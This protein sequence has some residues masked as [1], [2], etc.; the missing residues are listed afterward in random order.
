MEKYLVR[1]GMSLQQL[2]TLSVIHVTGTKGKG[3]TCAFVEAILRNHGFRTGFYSSPHLVAVRE[4]FR[5]NAKPISEMKFINYFW[6]VYNML[7]QLKDNPNDMPPYFKFLTILMFHIFIKENVDV[8]IIEVGIGGELDCT[9][10]VRNSVCTGIAR[11]GL[12]HTSVLGNTLESIAFQKSGIFKPGA[13][14]FTIPQPRNA[15]SVLH[16]R[17]VEKGC[18]LSIVPNLQS[19]PWK[20]SQPVLGIP[21][22]VQN[23]N[24]SLAIQLASSWMM[25]HKRRGNNCSNTSKCMTNDNDAD[26]FNAT[27]NNNYYVLANN[28]NNSPNTSLCFAKVATALETCKW[29][30]RTQ[31]LPRETMDFYIDGAHTIESIETCVSWFRDVTVKTGEKRRK[32]LIFNI[33]GARDSASLL[34]PLKQ[35]GFS[36]VFFVPNVTGLTTIA[37]HIN[38]NIN[39]NKEIERCQLHVQIWGENSVTANSVYDALKMIDGQVNSMSDGYCK[40][41]VLVTG[42]LHLVGA[43]LSIIDPNLSLSTKC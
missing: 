4:R 42:S 5:I 14:A 11:L 1:S 8:A 10:I 35:L 36:K 3:S 12:D 41:Q 13:P 34:N 38:A 20:K 30:G 28:N 7:N 21:C 9:N 31:F 19:Y 27:N 43:L 23:H 16:N 39:S 32:Y 15:M 40:P 26:V 22:K 18:S 29:P 25:R 6:P 17:A 2:D 24:A 37:D 33:T